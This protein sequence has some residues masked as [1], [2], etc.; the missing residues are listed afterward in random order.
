MKRIAIFG[1]PGSGKS[2]L[3]RKLSAQTGLPVVHLDRYYFNPGWVITSDAVFRQAIT[4]AIAAE[5]WITD[6]NYTTESQ[7]TGRLDRADT[8]ILLECPRWLCLWR[9][10]RR[11]V[12]YYGRVRPDQAPGCPE[13]L[14]WGFLRFV[15]QFPTKVERT[16]Q[17]LLSL[18]D[19]KRVYFLRN[20][21]EIEQ[22]LA[23]AT[24]SEPE[25][26]SSL[27]PPDRIDHA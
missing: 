5:C 12:S 26:G 3:A 20:K 1:S 22:F 15:W 4:R 8:L 6:G 10:I 23:T 11:I 21:A 27:L 25:I 9:V 13:R 19:Q 17:L 24:T 7:L 14:D 2:T 18:S 16:R